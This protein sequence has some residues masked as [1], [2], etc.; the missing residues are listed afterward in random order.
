MD[1]LFDSFY[2][3]SRSTGWYMNKSKSQKMESGAHRIRWSFGS[4]WVKELQ[5]I[6]K[7]IP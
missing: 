5:T 7:T 4:T 6:S 3:N 2:F 1:S